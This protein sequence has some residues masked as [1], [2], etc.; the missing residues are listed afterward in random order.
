MSLITLYLISMLPNLQSLF[1]SAAAILSIVAAVSV[2]LA[3]VED[4]WID[5]PARGWRKLWA[6]QMKKWGAA[7]IILCALI[8]ALIPS[9]KQLYFIA[10]GYAATNIAGIDKLPENLVKAANDWLAGL[11]K[12]LPAN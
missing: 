7:A 10:G 9:E 8:A 12:Q 3:M 4:G 2:V 6:N 11:D 1:V 5:S